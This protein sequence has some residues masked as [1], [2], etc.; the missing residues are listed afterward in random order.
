[1][2]KF[3]L[4][5]NGTNCLLIIQKMIRRQFL[6]YLNYIHTPAENISIAKYDLEGNGSN[7]IF[8][9]FDATCQNDTCSD[10]SY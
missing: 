6:L 4:Q 8:V 9:Q 1:M 3:A 10:L 7:E 2:H 5:A